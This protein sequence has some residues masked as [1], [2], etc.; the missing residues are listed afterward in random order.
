MKKIILLALFAIL[1]LSAGTACANLND[2][3]AVIEERYGGYRLV[4]DTDGQLWTRAEWE[5]GG[6]QKAKAG[7]F[8]YYFTRNGINIQMEVLFDGNGPDAYVKSQRFTPDTSIQIKEFKAY[9]PEVH[10]LLISPKAKSFVTYKELTRNF[11]DE[12]SPVTL[13]VV[14][15]ETPIT[16]KG[17]FYTLA[18][19]NVKDAGRLIKDAKYLNKDCYIHE[20]TIE[21]ISRYEADDCGETLNGWEWIK[22]QF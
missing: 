16:G 8:M 6:A 1:A 17:N 18:A 12:H 2:S 21:R 3:R 22:N 11:R 14:V 7:A 5:A 4:V 19:F 15:R 9:F 20:F 10:A 13:G